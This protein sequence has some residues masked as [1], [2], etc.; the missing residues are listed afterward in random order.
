MVLNSRTWSPGPDGRHAEGLEIVERGGRHDTSIG[1]AQL[2]GH[3]GMPLREALDVHLVDHALAPR[4]ARRAIVAPRERGIDHDGLRHP[5]RA[6]ALVAREIG[7]AMADRVAEERVAP[8]HR[9]GD[10]VRVRI[11]EELGGI[12]SV[13]GRRFERP[14]HPI[15]I[16]E[17][18]TRRRKV[19]VPHL[20]RAL[21]HRHATLAVVFVVETEL[22]AGG[23]LGEEREVDAGAVPRR[24]ERIGV[25]GPRSHQSST[26]SRIAPRGL[27]IL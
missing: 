10:R 6:V 3:V 27:G 14:V 2:P 13:P 7:V 22:D 20:V 4:D 16:A 5:G 25:A 21:R 23:V 11:E 1:A 19:H 12:E 26:L 18:G 9:P 24:A 17:T 8:R 15:P